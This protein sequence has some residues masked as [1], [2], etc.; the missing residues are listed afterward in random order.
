M[1]QGCLLANGRAWS[2][3]R[4]ERETGSG[5]S[6]LVS[7]QGAETVAWDRPQAGGRPAGRAGEGTRGRWLQGHMKLSW[8]R[9]K[10]LKLLLSLGFLL[11]F[12][13]LG[14]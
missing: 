6:G 9:E 14:Q 8:G 13:D 3:C 10:Q 12:K 7:I 5:L 4:C 2:K 11:R 1:A